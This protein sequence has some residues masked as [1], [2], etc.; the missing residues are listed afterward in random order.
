MSGEAAIADPPPRRY[1]GQHTRNLEKQEDR[2][3]QGQA[4][5]TYTLD[6][7]TCEHGGSPFVVLLVTV[8]GGS[9]L[10]HLQ[11]STGSVQSPQY[12]ERLLTQTY[13]NK[14]PA[15]KLRANEENP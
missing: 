2:R 6:K 11:L 3:R 12:A 15:H 9:A 4:R 1:G 10:A 5:P 8:W 13:K 14:N 7:H